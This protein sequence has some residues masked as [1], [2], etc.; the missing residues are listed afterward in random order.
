MEKIDELRKYSNYNLVKEKLKKYGINDVL[1]STRKDKKYMII[2]DN[3]K[4][5]FGAFGMEDATKHYDPI[6]IKNFKTRNASWKD[7][8]KYSPAFLS[9]Y[10]L[11]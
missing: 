1:I 6:R 3:K 4:I 8:P 11:W 2:H 9:Y 10:G 5:H 7:A